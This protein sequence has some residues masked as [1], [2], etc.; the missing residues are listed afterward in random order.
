[1]LSSVQLNEAKH[2]VNQ[3]AFVKYSHLKNDLQATL[4]QLLVRLEIIDASVLRPGSKSGGK[5]LGNSGDLKA[6]LAV[7]QNLTSKSF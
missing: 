7:E 1:M 3:W 4:L 2:P 6:R 5:R